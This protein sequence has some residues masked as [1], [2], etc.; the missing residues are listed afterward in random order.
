MRLDLYL[1]PSLRKNNRKL[2]VMISRTNSGNR[3]Y[4][5]VSSTSTTRIGPE[6]GWSY[7]G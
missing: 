4:A 3:A 7:C 6:K 5:E 2:Y 1:N